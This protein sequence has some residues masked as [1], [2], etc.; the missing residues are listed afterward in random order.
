LVLLI[1][2]S[3]I[4]Q[5]LE[6]KID[7][8]L[9]PYLDMNAWSG[10]VQI[11]KNGKNIFTKGY[12]LAN[13]EWKI[14]NTTDTKFRIASISKLFTEVAVL[15]LV[16]D[17]KLSLDDKLI[18]FIS[19][20]PRGSEITI[21]N[22]LNH[23]S[24]IPHLNSYPNYNELIKHSYTLGEIIDLFK[25]NYLDFKPGEKYNYSNS[26]YVLLAYIIEK[27]S[28]KTY[29]EY[30]H[31]TIWKPLDL[32]NTG[33]DNNEDILTNRAA[34]YQFNFKGDLVNAEFVDMDIKIGGGSLY[35][36]IS[37]VTK[38]V[39][40]VVGEE[41]VK[42]NLK[43]LPNFGES[44]GKSYFYTNGRVQG[45][46]HQVTHWINEKITIT[47]LGNHYSNLALPISDDVYKIFKGQ[48]YQIPENYLAQEI[49]TRKEELKKYEGTYDF[50][51]GPVGE[52]KVL[53]DRL[54]YSNLGKEEY[55]V[56]N[57][58]GND[59]FFYKQYWVLLRFTDKNE[60]DYKTLEW[61]MGENVYPAKKIK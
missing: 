21:K 49:K 5:N 3:T 23:T 15:K 31:S 20:Y 18:K 9:Q 45:F 26:G 28:K 37:D 7:N 8:Y 42:S 46:C 1:T 4:G 17:K 58:I 39:E 19:D 27:V 44:D 55:D 61:V 57:Y 29:E 11:S 56:L 53:D 34:G 32:K 16:E 36:T 54:T 50:G 43:E 25:N 48:S 38:F 2:A 13:R 59:T 24:G 47:I 52:I 41:I 51:F 33:I 60:K 14:P 10:N 40:A 22:L 30:L 12:G 35:S 6:K